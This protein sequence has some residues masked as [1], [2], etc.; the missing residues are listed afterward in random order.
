MIDIK[1]T[2]ITT[3]SPIFK[4]SPVSNNKLII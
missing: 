4:P 1:T 2:Y 3:I